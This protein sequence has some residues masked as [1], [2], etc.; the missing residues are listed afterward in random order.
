VT[1]A[2][3]DLKATRIVI[4]HRLSTIRSADTIIVIDKG[5]AVERGTYAE[6]MALG[7]VFA[8]QVSRQ[9]V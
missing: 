3:S 8:S 9:V 7:G 2:M 6:L 5:V 1:K 4:A